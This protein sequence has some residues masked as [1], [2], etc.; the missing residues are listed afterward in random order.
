M[1]ETT[2]YWLFTLACVFAFFFSYGM[3]EDL[4]KSE[5]NQPN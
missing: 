2:F 4:V 5:R 3:V 1:A